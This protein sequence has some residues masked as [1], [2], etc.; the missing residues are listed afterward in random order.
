[1]CSAG[2][3][4]FRR[5]DNAAF[6]RILDECVADEANWN[7]FFEFAVDKLS[8]EA[9]LRCVDISDLPATE[10]DF[11]EDLERA[12]TQVFPILGKNLE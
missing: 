4:S 2:C 1:M 11:P 8:R 6:A 7:C 9:T 12:R 3:F 5:G 10:I